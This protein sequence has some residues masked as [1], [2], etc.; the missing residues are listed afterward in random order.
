MRIRSAL[1]L[2]AVAALTLAARS[3][4]YFLIDQQSADESSPTESGSPLGLGTRMLQS[5]TPAFSSIDFVRLKLATAVGGPGLPAYVDVRLW[6]AWPSGRQLAMTEL[7]TIPDGFDGYV[8]FRFQTPVP[9]TP[10]TTY[11]INANRQGEQ[12][13]FWASDS[14]LGYPG[15]MGYSGGT[16][17]PQWDFWFQEGIVVP[18]PTTTALL[19][20][21]LGAL[22]AARWFRRKGQRGA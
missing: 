2:V 15:G 7:E 12:E 8:V 20:V 6:S 13:V 9:L 1:V 4:D 3:Q 21:G 10:G 14:R 17:R 11:F 5:F 16:A 18:E 22:G 19:F